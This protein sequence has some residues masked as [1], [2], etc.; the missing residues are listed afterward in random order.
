MVWRSNPVAGEILCT[1]P[2]QPWGPPSLLHTGYRVSFP[3]AKWVGCVVNAPLPSWYVRGWTLLLLYP[4][5]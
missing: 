5:I 4:I 3:G 1:C 2:D